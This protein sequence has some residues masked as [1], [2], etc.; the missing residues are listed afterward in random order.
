MGDSIK[1]FVVNSKAYDDGN[2]DCGEWV[3]FPI[4][5]AEIKAVYDRIGIDGIDFKQVFFDDFKTDVAGLQKILS[6]HTDI[7]ELNYLAV[8][9]SDLSSS[10]LAKLNAIAETAPFERLETFIDFAANSSCYVL[11]E[12]VHDTK[13]LG[14]YYLYQSDMVQMPEEWKGGIDPKAFGTYIQKD[15]A[16]IFTKAGFLMESGNEWL[17]DYCGKEE[18]PQIFR[19]SPQSVL[20]A[21]EKIKQDRS[22][23]RKQ[24]KQ[25]GKDKHKAQKSIKKTDIER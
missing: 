15:A 10:E 25:C 16:G 5:P 19:I 24:L 7:D 11:I 8:C 6:V 18:I 13:E 22:S 12:G 20:K 3:T 23:I 14:E 2:H 9:L 4:T 21:K 17:D 1:A